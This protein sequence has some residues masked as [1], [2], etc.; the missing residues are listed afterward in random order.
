MTSFARD[1]LVSGGNFGLPGSDANSAIASLSTP[2][3][4]MGAADDTAFEAVFTDPVCLLGT[5]ESPSS[6]RMVGGCAKSG[7]GIV[8]TLFTRPIET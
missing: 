4:E 6:A 2:P 3:V 8:R 5:E 7:F 1:E